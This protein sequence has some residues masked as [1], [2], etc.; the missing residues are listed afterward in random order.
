MSEPNQVIVG[1]AGMVVSRVLYTKQPVEKQLLLQ[2]AAVDDLIIR[3][4]SCSSLLSAAAKRTR[5]LS[6]YR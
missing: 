3:Y 6:T 5:I 1:I 2:H 4:D